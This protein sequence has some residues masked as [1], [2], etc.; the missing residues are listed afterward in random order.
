MPVM[1][2]SSGLDCQFA[3][4]GVM[5]LSDRESEAETKFSRVGIEMDVGCLVSIGALLC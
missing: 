5:Y 3:E 4:W 1:Y 2:T